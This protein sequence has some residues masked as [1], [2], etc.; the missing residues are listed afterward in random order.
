M[1]Q[2][3]PEFT[4]DD[5]VRV[6]RVCGYAVVWQERRRIVAIKA[7]PG[8]APPRLQLGIHA[9]ARLWQNVFFEYLLAVGVDEACIIDAIERFSDL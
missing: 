1:S 3:L 6:L 8:D 7:E 2:P 9:D 4:R 5:L